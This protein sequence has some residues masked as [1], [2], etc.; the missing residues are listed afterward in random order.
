M[1]DSTIAPV[2]RRGKQGAAFGYTKVHDYH[3]RI[4]SC[5]D[6]HQVIFSRLRGGSAGAARGAKS[7]LT[8]TVSR[9]RNAGASG[10]LTVRADSAFHSK[11]MLTTARRLDVRFSVTAR[12]DKRVRAA[13]EAI[14]ANAA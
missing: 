1:A 9:P 3:P 4:A 6:T 8:E 7:F 11:K 13:I 5:R 10:K 12:Q 2:Y 14:P